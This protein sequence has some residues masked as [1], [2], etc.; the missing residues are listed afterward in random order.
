MTSLIKSATTA[1]KNSKRVRFAFDNEYLMKPKP[2]FVAVYT[3]FSGV[4]IKNIK[5]ACQLESE[6]LAELKSIKRSANAWRP[7][8]TKIIESIK[9]E[10]EEK[11]FASLIFN[12]LDNII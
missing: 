4:L 8:R 6:A 7:R 1:T 3:K 10:D 11:A 5:S 2:A 9:D 12:P